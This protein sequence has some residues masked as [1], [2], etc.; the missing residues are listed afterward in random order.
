MSALIRPLIDCLER[1]RRFELSPERARLEIGE[2]S[3]TVERHEV[4]ASTPPSLPPL[5][6][7]RTVPASGVVLEDNVIPLRRAG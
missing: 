2:W 5:A 1:F 4:E 6:K 7:C 3:V